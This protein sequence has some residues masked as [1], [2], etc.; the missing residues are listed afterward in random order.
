MAKIEPSQ[1]ATFFDVIQQRTDSILAV[2]IVAILMFLIIPLPSF[3][4]D[5]LLAI[6]ITCSLMILLVP[7]YVTRP[8]EFSVFPGVLLIVTLFR[9][10]L[11][12]ASTRL[13]LGE[14]YAGDIIAAF[15][16]FV[17]KGNYVVGLVIFIILVIINFTVITK[18]SGRVA[19]VAA[20][21]TLDAMPGKQMAID[22][23]LNA[24]L[25]GEQDEPCYLRMVH[26]SKLRPS[27]Q[28]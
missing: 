13:I 7:M 2:A 28:T 10:S 16:S 25:I 27:V 14:G 6:N 9:L 17:V 18:G 21:F 20:R 19:E 5:L 24:G 8:S 26:D 22:A 4:L 11:N 12:V 23:D 15:G 3:L 1:R